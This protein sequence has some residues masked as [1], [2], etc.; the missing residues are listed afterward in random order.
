MAA[1]GRVRDGGG[2]G[3]GDDVEMMWCAG[4]RDVEMM[5]WNGVRMELGM[6]VLM[7]MGWMCG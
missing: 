1:E 5:W 2:V 4:C 6:D 7:D 3:C